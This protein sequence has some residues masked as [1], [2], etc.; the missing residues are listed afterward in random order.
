V[1][2]AANQREVLDPLAGLGVVAVAQA[3]EPASI[4]RQARALID[5][6]GERRALSERSRA[7]VD[8]HGAERVAAAIGALSPSVRDAQMADAAL[9]HAWRNDPRVREASRQSAPIA[10]EDH[11]RWLEAA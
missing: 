7:L 2:V 9:M 11:V 5:E 4:A 1:V 6:P 8:G 10:Y 3:P